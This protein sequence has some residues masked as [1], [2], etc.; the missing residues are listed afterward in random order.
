MLSADYAVERCLSV[1]HTPLLCVNG[2]TYPQCFSLSGS[3]TILVFAHQPEWQY[4]DGDPLNGAVECKGYEK[5]HDFRPQS[6][7]ISELTPDRA[8]VTVESE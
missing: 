6:G 2:Y 8:T 3:P 1:R 7:F 4:S 5:N